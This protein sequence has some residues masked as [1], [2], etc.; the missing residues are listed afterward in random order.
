VPDQFDVELMDHVLLEELQ[1]TI[2]LM[3]AANQSD[4]SLSLTQIDRILGVTG[5]PPGQ[6]PASDPVGAGGDPGA[7]PSQ[8]GQVHVPRP[9]GSTGAARQA[10]GDDTVATAQE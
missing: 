10:P 4:A 2:D 3:A 8:V 1:L 5:S 9:R 7:A 6:A